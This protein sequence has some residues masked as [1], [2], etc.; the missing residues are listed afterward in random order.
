MTENEIEEKLDQ[1]YRLGIISGIE[2]ASNKVF[3]MSVGL[4][5]KN[6]DDKAIEMKKISKILLDMSLERQVKH[7]KDY[8]KN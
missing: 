1:T 8:P 4:F 5:K 7:K 3:D 6:K 2:Q